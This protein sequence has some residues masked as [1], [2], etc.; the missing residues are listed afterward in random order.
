M[1]PCVRRNVIGI[2]SGRKHLQVRLAKEKEVQ[3]KALAEKQKRDKA[4]KERLGKVWLLFPH[5]NTHR[6]F[7]LELVAGFSWW[8]WLVRLIAL[9]GCL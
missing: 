3:K 9:R 8:G 7:S 4:E 5:T 2:N 1:V 6:I